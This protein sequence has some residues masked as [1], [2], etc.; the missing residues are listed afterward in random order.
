MTLLRR[1]GGVKDWILVSYAEDPGFEPVEDQKFWR[2]FLGLFGVDSGGKSMA[3]QGGIIWD[4]SDC[5]IK[6]VSPPYG[7]LA[8]CLLQTECRE[9][10]T[11][12]QPGP[13]GCQPLRLVLVGPNTRRNQASDDSGEPSGS[14]TPA[15]FPR[16]GPSEYRC[17][18]PRCDRSFPTNRGRGIHHQRAHKNWYDAQLQVPTDKARWSAEE[19]AML[20]RKEVQL[21]SQ[22]RPPRFINQEL[23]KAFP[24]RSLKAIKGRRKRLDYKEMIVAL[25]QENEPQETPDEQDEDAGDHPDDIFLTFLESLPEPRNQGFQATR[26]HKIA[27]E[28]RTQGRTST[29]QKLALYL[30]EIF[31]PPT[32]R[33][34]RPPAL[35]R[36]TELSK[37]QMRKR[38]F[39]A[40]QQMW[41]KNRQR[42]ITSIIED[43]DSVAHPSRK[44]MEPYWSKVMTTHSDA[45]PPFK[46]ERRVDGI[47]Q[48][49]T[50]D[51]LIWGRVQRTSAA[52]P[53]GVS[54]RLF[55]AIP[56][57]TLIR[58][59]NLLMWCG[60]L[61]EELLKSR[62]VF[63][64]KKKDAT[65][66][67]DFRSITIPS[68][69]VRGLHKILA[70]RMETSLDID[71]RQR[72]FRSTDGC[73]DNT[74]LL[75]II[76]R[77]HRKRFR[78]LY[79]ASLDISKAFDSVSH[80]AIAAV[81]TEIG[82]PGPMIQY[83][84]EVYKGS[85]TYLEEGTW[86]SAPIH[87]ERGVRQGDPLSSVIFN[88]AKNTHY[89]QGFDDYANE[90]LARCE[91]RLTDHGKILNNPDLINQRWADALYG[92]I[93]GGGLKKSRKAPH[94][95]QWVA[96]GTA[97]LT[98]KD[99]I[100]CNRLRIGAL[101][102]KSRSSRGRT[103]DRRCKA[104]C[105]AQE[106]LNHVLQQC[107]RTHA[108]R[109]KRHDAILNYMEHRIRRCGYREP[110]Y[111]TTFGLRK[112]DMTAV[113]GQTA[114]VIDAQV[115]SEQVDLDRAHKKKV[116]YYKEIQQ[117]IKTKH[118]VQTVK[119]TSATLSWKGVWSANS[120][121]ELQNLGLVRTNDLKIVST[122][123]LIGGIAEYRIFNATTS[124][125]DWRSGIG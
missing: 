110:H 123:V 5:A 66:P 2:L 89:Q 47:W 54:P 32:R 36:T 10:G 81:L 69:L 117:D 14:S 25:Q 52:G 59:Y 77:T 85:K 8:P 64:P 70:K 73:A 19:V 13:W 114:V 53:D 71:A 35:P 4:F 115:V 108:A 49:I 87:P 28:A 125:L 18:F 22:D 75:D 116:D 42:C 122:R 65:L 6:S 111:L 24:H 20:A 72:A 98:G 39:A 121:Q 96:D 82:I 60:K 56:S 15:I 78:S 63:L 29:I 30:R 88:K 45:T 84:I 40:T 12:A 119:F 74:F 76:L 68:V 50:T 34:R 3:L 7:G 23:L 107:H 62:T 43:L 41:K 31:P 48:P 11:P 97:F 17:E 16:P 44:I 102:T 99:F 55:R 92:K 104:G 94:Q 27:L 120:A 113:L 51:D 91:K 86:T 90:E 83:L 100:N 46:N 26:L 124:C 95:H 118:N 109:I 57:A 61:P 101:P 103:Q 38:K 33:K 106:T 37:R 21:M 93:D 105:F 1:V 9:E 58:I 80:S 67:G 112:P 79:M